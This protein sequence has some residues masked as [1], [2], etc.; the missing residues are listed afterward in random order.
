MARQQILRPDSLAP[1]PGQSGKMYWPGPGA[2]GPAPGKLLWKT[3]LQIHRASLLRLHP[4]SSMAAPAGSDSVPYGTVR[5]EVFQASG[6]S[7]SGPVQRLLWE[8]SMWTLQLCCGSG[9]C[10]MGHNGQRGG[11]NNA[12]RTTVRAGLTKKERGGPN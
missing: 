12:D 10:Y 7:H 2:G 5:N 8:S 1:A 11:K 6:V 4:L 9:R 3:S